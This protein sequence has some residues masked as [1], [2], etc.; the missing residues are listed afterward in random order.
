MRSKKITVDN[1]LTIQ[2]A[3]DTVPD[4]VKDAREN[5]NSTRFEEL[6]LNDLTL[7]HNQLAVF[8]PAKNEI[9][10]LCCLDYRGGR[11]DVSGERMTRFINF[12]DGI[13]FNFCNDVEMDKYYK[14]YAENTASPTQK[15]QI[16]FWLSESPERI[17]VG[18]HKRTKK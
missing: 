3:G 15:N 9:Y 10:K 7:L 11:F 4:M 6:P 5:R 12:Q 14:L 2:T 13:L 16:I 1:K 17:S 18:T 8:Y